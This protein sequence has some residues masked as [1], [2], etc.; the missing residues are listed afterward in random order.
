MTPRQQS[1][2]YAI[3]DL[4]RDGMA[5]SIREIA[6][7]V[8]LSGVSSVHKAITALEAQGRLIRSGSAQRA[9][10]RGHVLAPGAFNPIPPIR[11]RAK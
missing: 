6:A 9:E 5:P 10:N 2:L 11:A 3:R 1:V 4:T 8:G 7:H